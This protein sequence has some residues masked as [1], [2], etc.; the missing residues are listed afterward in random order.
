MEARTEKS[1]KSWLK[2]AKGGRIRVGSREIEAA[3][4][5]ANRLLTQEGLKVSV[6]PT[7]SNCYFSLYD[8]R[9]HNDLECLHAKATQEEYTAE[10]WNKLED[11][12]NVLDAVREKK[13]GCDA[14]AELVAA[15]KSIEEKQAT[16]T[17]LQSDLDKSNHNM[18]LNRIDYYRL[19][20]K[21]GDH[22]EYGGS[23]RA[24][25]WRNGW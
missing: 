9:Y 13:E 22:L 11:A 19:A 23:R 5:D 3:I 25:S 8:T 16:I 14:K 2:R 18:A 17:S 21:A 6:S 15:K 20:R 1:I 7:C 24:E 10:L 4:I 12:I